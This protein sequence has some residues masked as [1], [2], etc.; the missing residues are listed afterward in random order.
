MSVFVAS[1]LIKNIPILATTSVNNGSTIYSNV[2]HK[3][4]KNWT[5]DM[6]ALVLLTQ[7][8]DSVTIQQ[9]CSIDNVNWY[10]PTDNAG[11]TQGLVYTSLTASQWI[12]FTPVITTYI[13]FS[14][15]AGANSKVSINLITRE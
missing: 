5:G 14:V 2:L 7:G 11:N 1:G 15:V 10:T 3:E 9:Q 13:R 12:A 4:I 6:S 8:G